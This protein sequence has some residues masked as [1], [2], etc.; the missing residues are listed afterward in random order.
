MESAHPFQPR[1]LETRAPVDMPY[2]LTANAMPCAGLRHTTNQ[3]S[4]TYSS[5]WHAASGPWQRLWWE[6]ALVLKSLLLALDVAT[7]Q[8]T[9]EF[10][11]INPLGHALA[12]FEML[13]TS[14]LFALFL[15]AIRRQFRR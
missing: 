6:I 5:V 2:A 13:L 9:P 15:L 7:F 1:I 11:T 3:Y 10:V 8:K 12:L 14:G 4:E